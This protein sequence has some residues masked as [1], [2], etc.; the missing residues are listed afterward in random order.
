[1]FQKKL[2]GVALR[3]DD[4][5]ETKLMITEF[6]TDR[7]AA[8]QIAIG[9]GEIGHV[10]RHVMAVIGRNRAIGLAKQQPLLATHLDSPDA[11]L[12]IAIEHRRR[13]KNGFIKS[14]DAL[15]STPERKTP[16]TGCRESCRR[17]PAGSQHNEIDYPKDRLLKRDRAPVE[18]KTGC[19][20]KH[21]GSTVGVVPV[22]PNSARPSRCDR[23]SLAAFGSADETVARQN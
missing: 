16:R 1:M 9:S 4:F 3:I 8:F 5:F 11:I 6:L 7:A 12:L 22:G 20:S 14:Q 19:S 21:P 10:D 13:T 18:K 15:Y 2:P 23:Q 17:I